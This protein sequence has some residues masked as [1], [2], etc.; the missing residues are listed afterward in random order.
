MLHGTENLPLIFNDM[1]KKQGNRPALLSREDE[2]VKTI[3][4]FEFGRQVREF[5]TGL[6]SLGIGTG[7]RIAILSENRPEWLISDLAIQTINAIS[8]PIYATLTPKEI[9]FIIADSGASA[10]ILSD[11]HQYKKVASIKGNTPFLRHIIG[12]DAW[13][14]ILSMEK[15]MAIGREEGDGGLVDAKICGIKGDDIFSIIYTS[16]TTGR[17]KGV[18]IS[19]AN[20]LSNILASLKSI[21]VRPDDL[22]L[23]FLPLSHIFERMVHHL[24]IHQGASIAYSK[25]FAYVGA[26]IALFK[27]TL[28]AGVPFFFERIRDKIMDNVGNSSYLK[29]KLFSW[30][31]SAG[32]RRFA[33]GE[34]S[35]SSRLAHNLVLNRLKNRLNPRLRFFISGGAPLP[36]DVGEFFWALGIPILEGYGLTETSPVVAVNSLAAVKLGTVGRPIPGVEV[37]IA[38]GG[39]IQ[40]KGPNVM[41]GYW[42]MP[43]ATKEAIKDGWFSTGDIGSVDKDGFLTI[44]DRKKDIIITALGK[45]V[46][47]QRLEALLRQNRYIK[48]AVIFGDRRPHLAALI[49]PEM[50]RLKEYVKEKA[51]YYKNDEGLIKD[52]M[53]Y[54]FYEKIIHETLKE[55][56]RFEQIRRFALIPELSQD[57]GELTPTLKVKRRVVEEK[58]KPI[59]DS[60]YELP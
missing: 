40:V 28:M 52:R 25:G 47:P 35:F 4:W 33:A 41:K 44:T 10:I 32:K 42:N 15:L 2:N 1:V 39:E 13:E 6:A 60:L 49:I 46:S 7:E 3:P 37:G 43:E 29:R 53:V 48:D 59:I 50:E 12:F 18:M 19:H 27:P 5:A 23:S 22:Y 11:A 45:N 20:L 36:K 55:L 58:Y 16:G 31:Y 14:G 56:A 17:P 24:I 26:D 21:I 8:V 54:R 9:E 30:A 34:D 51:I 57:R 38:E